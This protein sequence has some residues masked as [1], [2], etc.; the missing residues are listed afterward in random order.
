MALDRD[1]VV[2]TALRLLDEVGLEGLTLRRITGTTMATL[3]VP[4]ETMKAFG[5]GA[6]G[7]TIGFEIIGHR[8]GDEAFI[9]P[10]DEVVLDV[11]RANR[12]RRPVTF[13]ATIGDD[14]APG[15]DIFKYLRCDGITYRMTP[16]KLDGKTR[17][18]LTLNASLL[19][20]SSRFQWRALQ[21]GGDIYSINAYGWLQNYLWTFMATADGYLYN[22]RRADAAR[23]LARMEE[24]L[25][26]ERY[27]DLYEGVLDELKP[28]YEYA[29]RM[30]KYEELKGMFR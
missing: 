22:R 26:F 27:T 19:F 20:D 6:R 25:P 15:L 29:R 8:Y 13:S 18:S 28:L 9:L 7:A 16:R 1:T 14:D 24:L 17:V 12:W 3:D 21:G 23:T 2:R 4:K 11:L 30:E 10:E 5:G